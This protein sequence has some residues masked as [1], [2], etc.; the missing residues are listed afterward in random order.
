MLGKVLE[1]SYSH[2]LEH[3]CFGKTFR[4]MVEG[5]LVTS[6]LDWTLANVALLDPQRN[7]FGFSDHCLIMWGMGTGER[8]KG[9]KRGE[10]HF[11][12]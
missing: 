8:Q 12:I 5:R 11:G 4:R 7:A 3:T 9:R 1:E 6:K 2:G 10:L